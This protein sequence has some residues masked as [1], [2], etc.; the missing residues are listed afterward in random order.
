MY[1]SN[2]VGI[3]EDCADTVAAQG[4]EGKHCPHHIP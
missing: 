4:S 1:S 2:K 3:E